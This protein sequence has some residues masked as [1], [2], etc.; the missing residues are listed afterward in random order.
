LNALFELPDEVVEITN[1]LSPL[2]FN[3]IQEESFAKHTDGT[4]KAIFKSEGFT[5]WNAAN[6]P[7][8]E[9]I[10][11]GKEARKFPPVAK[12]LLW[13]PGDRTFC[14]AFGI[15]MLMSLLSSW[16]WKNCSGVRHL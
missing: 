4:A 14:S 8:E 7:A 13:C 10:Q 6:E 12:R 9:V 11:E 3:P 1:W 16:R 5:R 15:P 2:N